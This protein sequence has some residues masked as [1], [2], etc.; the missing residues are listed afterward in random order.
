MA[1]VQV[2]PDI[3]NGFTPTSLADLLHREIHLPGLDP[4]WTHTLVDVAVATDGGSAELTVHSQPRAPLSL[5]HHLRVT[6]WQPAAHIRAHDQDGNQLAE[7]KL[8]A[9]LRKGQLVELGGT[10]YKVMDHSWPGRD[11][12]SGCCTGTIDWQHAVLRPQPQPAHVPV[13]AE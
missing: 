7:V 6:S 2:F 10:T 11:P 9:P 4:A 5:D 12:V 3:P 13:A 8:D 1:R